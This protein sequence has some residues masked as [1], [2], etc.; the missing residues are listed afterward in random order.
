M[1]KGFEV[2]RVFCRGFEFSKRFLE[3]SGAFWQRVRFP[4]FFFE[5]SG[6]SSEFEI[7]RTLNEYAEP[8]AAQKSKKIQ[9]QRKV[10]LQAA[11]R[12]ARPPEGPRKRAKSRIFG[13]NALEGSRKRAKS[14]TLCDVVPGDEGYG[15]SRL[16]G[17]PAP[18]GSKICC[19]FPNALLVVT[20]ACISL[21]N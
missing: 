2:L 10:P 13:Q 1:H 21:N 14:R 4:A 8:S 20:L 5:P 7:C 17:L 3:P 15:I 9:R 12:C 19:R 6:V 16:T 11:R 18:D